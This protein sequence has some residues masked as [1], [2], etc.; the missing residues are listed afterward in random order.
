MVIVT[1]KELVIHETCL[2]VGY[3]LI[4]SPMQAT[5]GSNV[6]LVPYN[7]M[8]HTIYDYS[9][10]KMVHAKVGKEHSNSVIDKGPFCR[11]ERKAIKD[12]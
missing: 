5:Q 6:D 7:L 2:F 4:V 10:P 9:R 8:N 1:L 12:V 3:E 11:L